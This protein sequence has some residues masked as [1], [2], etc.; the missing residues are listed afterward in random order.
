MA[1][2][3]IDIRRQLIGSW[4]LVTWEVCDADGTVTRPLGAGEVGQLM[5][6]EGGRMSAQLMQPDQPRFASDNPRQATPEEKARAWSDYFGYFGTYTIDEHA[7]AVTHHIEGSWF[8]NLVG[9]AQKRYYRFDGE[10]LVLNATTAWGE[11]LIIW[12]KIG[13]SPAAGESSAQNSH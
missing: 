9:E 11:V 8:P 7:R 4:R 10:Q 12:E 1:G 2:K 13:S 6:D 5:Y 3:E